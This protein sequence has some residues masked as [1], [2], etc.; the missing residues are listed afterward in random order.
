MT[1]DLRQK[2]GEGVMW[3]AQPQASATSQRLLAIIAKR[4]SQVAIFTDDSDCQRHP[5]VRYR[6]FLQLLGS[7][8]RLT[9]LLFINLQNGVFW[10]EL[11][12]RLMHQMFNRHYCCLYHLSDD[13]N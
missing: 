10:I 7:L 6:D 12:P 8:T 11:V 4:R 2:S 1:A 13:L 5:Y 9:R 3:E